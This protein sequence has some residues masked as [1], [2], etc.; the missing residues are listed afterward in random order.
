LYTITSPALA[1]LDDDGDYDL[2]LGDSGTGTGG[3]C[4]GFENTGTPSAPVWSARGDWDTPAISGHNV[5]P[6]LADLD[7]DGD[8]DLL[9][10]DSDGDCF[11]YEN[12]GAPSG[13]VWT[14]RDDWDPAGTGGFH[15]PALVDLDGDGDFDL[16]TG[17]DDGHVYGYENY[18][19][20]LE[21]VWTRNSAW[22]S[23]GVGDGN[24]SPAF[25]DLDGDGDHDLLIGSWYHCYAYENTGR[26]WVTSNP[27]SVKMDDD[28][29]IH[30]VFSGCVVSPTSLD[31][32]AVAMG[33]YF[34]T[35][36][37]IRNPGGM[38]L[39]GDVTESCDHYS[40]IS[41]G[42]MYGLDPGDSVVVTVRF[43]PDTLGVLNCAIETGNADCPAVAC[44]ATGVNP[45]QARIYAQASFPDTVT[46]LVPFEVCFSDSSVGV[47]TYREWDFCGDA[48]S[49]AA[50]TCFTFV[51]P[52]TCLTTLR[53][54]GD[55]GESIDTVV[56]AAA[57]RG[58]LT[59]CQDTV[60]VAEPWE[61]TWIPICIQSITDTVSHF[62]FSLV[63]APDSLMFRDDCMQGDL[64]S[65]GD[66][67]PCWADTVAMDTVV[68][69]DQTHSS[70]AA[71]LPGESGSILWVLFEPTG[72]QYISGP[73]TVNAVLRIVS[74]QFDV[75][76]F[77]CGSAV[78]K[79]GYPVAIEDSPPHPERYA[80]GRPYPNPFNPQVKIPF[81]VPKEGRVVIRAFDVAGRLVRTIL[82]EKVPVGRHS[83][84]WDGTN[85][86]GQAVSSG[87]YYL[88]MQTP[89]FVQTRKAVL[90]K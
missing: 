87:V 86:S 20:V 70:D 47:Y 30:A 69:G 16:M 27:T 8:Y 35:T 51:R 41:G 45:I 79:V 81:A 50:D 55:Y 68:A 6:A 38:T 48:T 13:P 22:D 75:S 62:E 63:Y 60:W 11:A 40:I 84:I 15:T 43:Q 39:A 78:I 12:T 19:G 34:D 24:S 31:F 65:G 76:G 23:P 25:A 4:H 56:V 83:A 5:R 42:G 32:G 53:V 28:H 9:I 44:T 80:L 61:S 74:P 89:D 49:S 66:W 73:D 1:D 85:D 54:W 29:S 77:W 52:E 58:F 2:L 33:S 64:T 59:F 67:E 10:G 21:P 46:G 18:G 37:T 14:D 82:D 57:A 17:K 71:I 72:D 36:F 26:P 88:R 7:D 3:V 90:L